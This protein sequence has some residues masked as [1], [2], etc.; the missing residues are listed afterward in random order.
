[1]KRRFW[2]AAFLVAGISIGGL[3][4]GCRS[5]GTGSV[6]SRIGNPQGLRCSTRAPLKKLTRV[7]PFQIETRVM[8]LGHAESL[9]GSAAPLKPEADPATATGRPAAVGPDSLFAGNPELA[10][11]LENTPSRRWQ[12]E[13]VANQPG[14]LAMSNSVATEKSLPSVLQSEP[15]GNRLPVEP[16]PSGNEDPLPTSEALVRVTRQPAVA[17]STSPAPIE[18]STLSEDR[19]DRDSPPLAESLAQQ[20]SER[21]V[22][23]QA[24]LDRLLD[25]L[26]TTQGESEW[27]PEAAWP[28]THHLANEKE[29]VLQARAF[30]PYQSLRTHHVELLNASQQ[31]YTLPAAPRNQFLIAGDLPVADETYSKGPNEIRF[32]QLPEDH[33]PSIPVENARTTRPEKIEFSPLPA[34]VSND[35]GNLMATQPAAQNANEVSISILA[36]E[37]DTNPATAARPIQK[38]TDRR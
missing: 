21:A 25:S 17:S 13:R 19:P 33:R 11:A 5:A 14:D 4:L 35:H 22:E 31:A 29:V 23:R 6:L 7:L 8:P 2:I 10:Q 24:E 27:K 9:A 3:Q 28:A 1:M 15:V 30:A 16:Q 34:S 38:P 18:A 32:L 37:P 20:S 36:P 26:E 12:L